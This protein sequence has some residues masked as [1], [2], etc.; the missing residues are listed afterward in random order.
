MGKEFS[1]NKIIIGSVIALAVIIGTFI[2]GRDLFYEL[3]VHQSLDK[4]KESSKIS[5]YGNVICNPSFTHSEICTINN[6]KSNAIAPISI[7]RVTIL[8]PKAV[9]TQ[10]AAINEHQFNAYS[11]NGYNETYTIELNNIKL[12]NKNLLEMQ[13]A[14]YAAS[15]DVTYGSGSS[16]FLATILNKNFNQKSSLKI[17]DISSVNSKGL[18]A[19]D[20][21]T[22]LV[23]DTSVYTSFAYKTTPKFFPNIGSKGG[24][25][26]TE[27]KGMTMESIS[28]GFKTD[29]SLIKDLNRAIYQIKHPTSDANMTDAAMVDDK[30]VIDSEVNLML[31]G[32]DPMAIKASRDIVSDIIDGKRGDIQFILINKNNKD[33][34]TMIDAL[35]SSLTTA[36]VKPLFTDFSLH[37]N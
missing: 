31:Y 36:N 12:M 33:M 25:P 16:K 23:G 22:L 11:D 6:V 7:E 9:K 13:I 32:A 34:S 10:F 27:L 19:M 4:L 21:I 5:S 15:V 8:N 35:S 17:T 2:L 1:R 14:S 30:M 28:F 3:K 18:T 20:K 26:V 37:V 24:N 29:R